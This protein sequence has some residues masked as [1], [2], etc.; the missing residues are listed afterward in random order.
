MREMF[1]YCFWLNEIN[2]SN[3][4]IN[5]TAKW[6]DMFKGCSGLLTKKIPDKIKIIK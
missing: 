4:I 6:S 2:I 5:E 3:F 1:I